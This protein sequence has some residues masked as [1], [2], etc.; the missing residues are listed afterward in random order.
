MYGDRW[1]PVI[2]EVLACGLPNKIFAVFNFA[3]GALIRENGEIK[4]TTKIS[5]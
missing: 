3:V 5:M 4:S 2:G 1:S